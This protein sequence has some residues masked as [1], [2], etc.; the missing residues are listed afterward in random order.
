MKMNDYIW[1]V[2]ISYSSNDRKEVVVP[3]ANILA[4]FG[5]KSWLDEGEIFVGDS[6]YG[7]INDGLLK[8]RFVLVIFSPNFF[9]S[10]WTKKELDGAMVKAISSDN[11]VILPV[12]HNLN[13]DQIKQHTTILAGIRALRTEDGLENVAK[14]I[15]DVVRNSKTGKRIDIP[16]FRGRLT[17]KH[18]M[19][20]PEGYIIMSNCFTQG[21]PSILLISALFSRH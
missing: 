3:L 13:T 1:D 19:G 5:I 8:S 11:N 17:K 12:L 20:C 15:I 7:K 10:S 16:E 14:E 2:F 21:S 6:I 9:S 18:L 4:A